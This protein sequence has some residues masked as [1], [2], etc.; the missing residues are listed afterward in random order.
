VL[1][2]LG[3]EDEIV[4]AVEV[5]PMREVGQRD[6]GPGP[7]VLDGH[8]VLDGA[9]LGI[10]RDVVRPDLPP[11]ADAPEQ[12]AHGMAFHDMTSA[13]VTSAAKMMRCL[14]PSTT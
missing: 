8:D 7:G 9:V 12:V 6:V 10:T 1:V 13:G 2:A 5:A 14:P 11:K 3:I 4:L